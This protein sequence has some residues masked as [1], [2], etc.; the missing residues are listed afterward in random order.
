MVWLMLCEGDF[1][2]DVAELGTNCVS[3]LRDSLADGGGFQRGEQIGTWCS[4]AIDGARRDRGASGG[5]CIT[6]CSVAERRRDAG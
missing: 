2:G 6:V 5:A 4:S 1:T 3:N